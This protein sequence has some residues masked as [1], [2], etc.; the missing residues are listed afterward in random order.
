MESKNMVLMNLFASKE[1]T[2]GYREGT[3]GHSGGRR[4]WDEW[5]K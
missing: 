3:S 1:W 2:G 4:E 5:R